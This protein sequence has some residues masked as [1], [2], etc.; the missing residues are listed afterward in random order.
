MQHLRGEPQQ[1]KQY[2]YHIT[3][4][5]VCLVLHCTADT[6]KKAIAHSKT[7]WLIGNPC[8]ISFQFYFIDYNVALTATAY[9][10]HVSIFSLL[11]AVITITTF[12]ETQKCSSL[13]VTTC[14]VITP[15][16][17]NEIHV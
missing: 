1:A 17:V 7:S 2:G 8:K 13:I 9:N 10:K 12:I 11:F 16:N 6:I 5:K 4:I 3:S 14:N 15:H